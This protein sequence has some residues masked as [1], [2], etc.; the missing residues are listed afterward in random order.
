M[1]KCVSK[2]AINEIEYYIIFP[3]FSHSH[4]NQKQ[5]NGAQEKAKAKRSKL[6]RNQRK[7]KS[8]KINEKKRTSLNVFDYHLI[9]SFN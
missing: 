2:S 9:W 1:E 7:K 6:N 5:R 4:G 3:L 8:Q